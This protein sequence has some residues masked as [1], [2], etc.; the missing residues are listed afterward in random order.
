[1]V[2]YS[3]DNAKLSP[4]VCN[5]TEEEREHRRAAGLASGWVFSHECGECYKDCILRMLRMFICQ[6]L[7]LSG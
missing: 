4:K 1:M 6:S 2:D 3:T 7:C 5:G